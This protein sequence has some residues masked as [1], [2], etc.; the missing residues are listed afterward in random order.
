[1]NLTQI[2]EYLINCDNFV[3]NTTEVKQAIEALQ[4]RPSYPIVLIGG[5]NGKGSSVAYLTTILTNA[6]YNVGSYTS[7]HIFSYNERIQL[8]NQNIDDT[9][10]QQAL[11][12]VIQAAPSNLGLFKTF[13]LASHLI[14]AQAKIDVAIVEVGL[15]GAMDATNLFEPTISAI[16]TIDFDHC[17]ILG[18]DLETIAA[19]KVKI[20]RANKPAIYADKN[21]PKKIIEYCQQNS[22]KLEQLGSNYNYV[23]HEFCWDYISDDF[24]L[25]SIPFPSM[26]GDIQLQN[27]ALAINILQKLPFYINA[28]QI[29]SGM[30]QTAL[31]GRFQVLAGAPQV[32]LDVAHNPQAVGIMLK[33]MLKLP[34]TKHN[35]AVFGVAS[36]KD[37]QKILDLT[38][39]S[40]DY[41]Y[42]API[43]SNRNIDNITV[44]AYLKTKQIKNIQLAPSIDIATKQAYCKAQELQAKLICFGSFLVVEQAHKA[45]KG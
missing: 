21:P 12:Q 40:F 15:G 45:L 42:I 41:W 27:A 4:I 37:W 34:F 10:L 19:E 9:K 39:N 31:T 22:I 26:R 32:V 44:E 17:K 11:Q 28:N 36:D 6:G 33:S 3:S 29:K 24:N 23:T 38:S 14:F 35:I 16:T 20:Y 13:T 30:L 25:Y 7:P 1:M 43:K 8:N 18:N 5:T 2:I